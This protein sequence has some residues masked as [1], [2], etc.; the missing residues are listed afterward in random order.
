MFNVIKPS[1]K[2]GFFAAVT[3]SVARYSSTFKAVHDAY[4]LGLKDYNVVKIA[5]G[6]TNGQQPL[7]TKI[8]YV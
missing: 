2:A 8:D 7:S 5:F 1:L 4:N 6:I 3:A